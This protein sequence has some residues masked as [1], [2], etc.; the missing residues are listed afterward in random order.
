[1]TEVEQESF[2]AFHARRN[3]EREIEAGRAI[4]WKRMTLPDGT[5]GALVGRLGK[6]E[7]RAYIHRDRDET[8]LFAVGLIVG[9]DLVFFAPKPSL[10]D[11]KTY[12]E[13]VLRAEA[14]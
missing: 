6:T 1:M 2:E 13:A 3:K 5:R 12:A 4:I 7:R 14:A 9:R 8:D 11:A 10:A